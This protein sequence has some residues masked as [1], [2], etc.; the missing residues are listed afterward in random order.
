MFNSS[1]IHTPLLNQS[2]KYYMKLE[3][4]VSSYEMSSFTA[5][6][7][8]RTILQQYM[9]HPLRI[10]NYVA[11]L[12][13]VFV[14]IRKR[15]TQSEVYVT[16]SILYSEKGTIMLRDGDILCQTVPF[17]LHRVRSSYVANYVLDIP[18]L[19]YIASASW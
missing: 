1:K 14:E 6:I 11:V 4:A 10:H 2:R 9:H 12:N 17:I 15:Q 5:K 18:S 13:M 3:K 19:V 8:F 16:L 7:K